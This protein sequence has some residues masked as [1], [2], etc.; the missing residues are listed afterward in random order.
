MRPRSHFWPT[1]A[2]YAAFLRPRFHFSPMRSIYTAF[3]APLSLAACLVLAIYTAF[4]ER[5]STSGSCVPADRL[6]ADHSLSNRAFLSFGVSDSSRFAARTSLCLARRRVLP[7]LVSP[8]TSASSCWI[9]GPP[10][11][12]GVASAQSG[13][14]WPGGR[15]FGG[16]T[17]ASFPGPW[18]ARYQNLCP[19][20]I[21][22]PIPLGPRRDP[23]R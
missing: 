15:L 5:A 12:P 11:V 18:L 9:F 2:I 14:K 8:G 6:C 21:V 7:A 4:W 19:T 23:R 10:V 20:R 1:R 22:R 3:F 17:R 16:V 13:T